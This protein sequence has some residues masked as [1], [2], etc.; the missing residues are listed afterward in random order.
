MCQGGGIVTSLAMVLTTWNVQCG[1]PCNPGQLNGWLKSHGGFSG[2]RINYASLDRLGVTYLGTFGGES[3]DW[4][5]HVKPGHAAILYIMSARQWVIARNV[6]GD[7]VEA[8]LTQGA[9]GSFK[10]GDV[11]TAIVYIKRH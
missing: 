4:V 2:F 6:H 5:P 8:K 7:T 9:M 10:L 3:N 1:G 11:E